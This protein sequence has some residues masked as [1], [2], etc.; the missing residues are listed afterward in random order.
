MCSPILHGCRKDGSKFPLE[1]SLSSI[2]TSRGRLAVAF[3][4]DIT[5]RKRAE[6]ALRNS[7]LELRALAGSLL[8]ASED[9]RRRLAGELHDDVTQRLAFLAI[10]IGKTAVGAYQSVEEM[11][12]ALHFL[13]QQVNRITGDVRRLSH[14]LHPSMI[15]DLGL[16][17]AMEELFVE[18]GGKH[19]IDVS[20]EGLTDDAGVAPGVAACLY[21]IA[22]EGLRNVSKHAHASEVNGSLT[23]RDGE[24]EFR[25]SDSGV[26]FL[27]DTAKGQTGLGIISMKE[28]VRLVC[29]TVTIHSLLDQGTE[30]VVLVPVSGRKNE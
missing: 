23:I 16:S 5:A 15:E 20:F 2:E 7:E 8:T 13:Q 1:I 26:G 11:R 25:L 24:I 29:G 18:F 6:T 4:T 30:I 10:E 12:G 28:R 27:Y 17:T 19:R 22:Q 9:E 21:R 3:I 14:G